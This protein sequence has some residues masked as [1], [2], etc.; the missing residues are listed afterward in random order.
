MGKM[1]QFNPQR[2]RSRC[3]PPSWRASALAISVL[4]VALLATVSAASAHYMINTSTGGRWHWHVGGA[5]IYFGTYNTA[6]N[7]TAA[8]YARANVQSWNHP[9]Y[10]TPVSYQSHI[11]LY[12]IYNSSANYCGLGGGS[13]YNATTS[14]FT[15]AYGLYN[16]WCNPP[17]G[18]DAF[19]WKQ[20][21][22]CQE[23]SHAL[24]LGHSNYGD[25]MGLTY[26]Q[27]DRFPGE[28]YFGAHPTTDITDQYRYH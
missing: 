28:Y 19:R 2:S 20:G 26:W 9:V 6:V 22:F 23:L 24:G 15:H 8:D 14:H 17:A 27:P 5:S 4:T 25:C 7:R 13:N 21:I 18:T 10:F 11:D 3:G 1:R 16:R 12:D